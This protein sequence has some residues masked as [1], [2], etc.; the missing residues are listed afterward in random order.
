[1]AIHL[2]T[3]LHFILAIAFL[4]PRPE[5]DLD[6]KSADLLVAVLLTTHFT[7]ATHPFRLKTLCREQ[8][9][10]HFTVFRVA[11]HLFPHKSLYRDQGRDL[12]L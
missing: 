5:P 3:L 12:Y 8:V 9:P 7:F 4:Y 6:L 1:M 11:T 2:W 10:V